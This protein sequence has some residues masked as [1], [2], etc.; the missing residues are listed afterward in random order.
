M[1]SDS[2]ACIP[3]LL[4]GAFDRHNFGDLLFPH[5]AATLLP[6]KNLIFSGLADR[7]LRPYGGHQV[8]A[9]SRIVLELGDCPVNILHAGGELLTCD[10][11][12][13][14]V[15]LLPPEQAQSAIARLDAHPSIKPAWAHEQ[16]GLPDLAPYALSRRLFP[17]ARR[18][19]FNSVG[20]V[21]LGRRDPALRHEVLA[22][23]ES[24]DVVSVR[25]E[26]TLEQLSAAGLAPRLVPDPA[27]MVAE[28]FGED[29]RRQAHEGETARILDSFPQGYIAIQFSADFGDDATLAEIAAQLDRISH[30][31]GLGVVFFRAGAAPWHDELECYRRCATH[32]HSAVK[33][34]SS[35]QLWDICALLAH[36]R[37]YC[38]SSLH[39]R[40]V[41]MAFA[42]PRVNLRHPAETNPRTKQAA[43]ASTWEDPGTPLTVEVADLAQGMREAM[44]ADSAALRRTASDL[45]S[46][47]RVEFE[48]IRASLG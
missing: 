2:S 12:Q 8:L 20:G 38:G 24:A 17:L 30:E 36:S 48:A 47:Y 37:A 5:I 21:D 18:I 33:L 46:R 43:Y 42:L 39:G 4:F 10:A 31:T 13:A 9:L 41:A 32:M 1:D 35:L 29:I 14:A 3:T 16:L 40:I 11:W 45:A 25:D 23:L 15:M 27:A 7:D 22:K 26:V 6:G 44:A 28:L 34:F 19:I